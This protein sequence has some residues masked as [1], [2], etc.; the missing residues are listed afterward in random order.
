M[1]LNREMSMNLGLPATPMTENKELFGELIRV[2]NALRILGYS[3]DSYTGAL[4]PPAEDWP[5]LGAAGAGRGDRVIRYAVLYENVTAGNTVSFMADA[6]TFKVR[7]AVSGTYNCHGFVL[8][9]GTAG[10]WAE[11]C[12]FG[13]FLEFAPGTLT[14]GATYHQSATA[15]LIAAGGT[16]V[17]GFAVSDTQLFFNP[18]L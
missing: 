12:L 14:I 2:Y 7:K 5:F 15:G 17:I 16:Q 4:S 10:A 1:S 9:D 13:N 8:K 3:L 6:G 11:V 18:Q